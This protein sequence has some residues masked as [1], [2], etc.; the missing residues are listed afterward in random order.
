MANMK[1]KMKLGAVEETLLIT[2]YM[3]AKE[4]RRKDAIL[5]DELACDLVDK[6]DYDF[7]KFDNASMSALGCVIRGRHFDRKV[8]DFIRRIDRPVVV[9]IGCGLD[10]RYQRIKEKKN[11]VFYELDLPEVMALRERLLPPPDRN[12]IPLAAS[13]LESGWMDELRERHSGSRFIFVIEGVVMYFYEK[14]VRTLLGRLASRFPGGEI[15]FDVCGT[16]FLKKSIKN[17][18]V[19]HTSAHFRCGINDGRVVERWVPQLKMTDSLSYMDIEKGRWGF[20][21]VLIRLIPG[22]AR[23]FSSILG[24][25]IEEKQVENPSVQ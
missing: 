14:Q 8:Q 16:M 18:S 24:Y 13:L 7:T 25:K 12:D 2:L 11:A 9:N 5:Y 17:D 23:K 3:R 1:E 15:H 6:I 4:S 10:T 22:F 20:K 19:K 21:G